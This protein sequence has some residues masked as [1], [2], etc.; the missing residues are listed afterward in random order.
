VLDVLD[1]LRARPRG[2]GLAQIAKAAKLPRSS[3]FRY[4]ATLEARGYVARDGGDGVYRLGLAFPGEGTRLRELSASARPL[5][6]VL[7]DRFQETINLGV[8]D[9]NSVVYLDVIE[10]PMAIRFAARPGHRDHIHSTALGKALAAQLPDEDVRRILT[11][12]GMGAVTPRTITDPEEYLRQLGTVRRNG[13]AVDN[14]ENEEHGGCVAV[15]IAGTDVPSA[16]SL[17]A[18]TARLS[19]AVIAEI[20]AALRN[21]AALVADELERTDA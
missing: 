12:D 13:F 11:A 4:L 14:G 18:P 3:A 6:Q 2:A 1:V 7:R 19:P 9:G 5:L 16:I 15:A 21:T 8:L 10:S 20:A 17:S